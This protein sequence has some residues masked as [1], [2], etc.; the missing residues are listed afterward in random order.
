MHPTLIDVGGFKIATFGLMMVVAFLSSLA[1]LRSRVAS[2]GI[3]GDNANDVAFYSIIFGILGA[4]ILFILQDL[5]HYLANR[6]ELFAIQFQ[7]LTSFGGFIVGG[8]AAYLV[9]R[10]RKINPMA[11]L[12]A[13]APAFL[14]GHAIGRIGCLFNGCCHGQACE[15]AFPFAAY[16]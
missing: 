10:K 5:P 12:D 14:L 13:A 2:R 6:K 3:S 9:C 1:L 4:R 16:S 15:T 11:F 8:I 7:G